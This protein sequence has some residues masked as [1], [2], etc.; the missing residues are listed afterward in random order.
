VNLKLSNLI[1]LS[2]GFAE[3]TVFFIVPDVCLSLITLKSPRSG[4][5]A[6]LYALG[7]ALV[8]GILTFQMAQTYPTATSSLLLAL[9][10]IHPAQMQAVHQQIVEKGT[11]AI[12]LGPLYGLPYKLYVVNGAWTG[13]S[14]GLILLLSLPARLL[15]FL[16]SVM[17]T[18]V[19]NKALTRFTDSHAIKLVSAS[20]GGE[21][22]T[23][24][25][26]IILV[27]NRSNC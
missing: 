14:L 4:F 19:C 13:K 22:S 10:G 12:F 26:S 6:C 15:R 20:F 8:G 18:S 23:H 24:G 3:A 16:F 7:G 9:P 25:I 21:L 11:L 2:W 5:I 1:A 27:G 17:I